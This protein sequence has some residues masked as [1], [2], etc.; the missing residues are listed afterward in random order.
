M[1]DAAAYQIESMLD[2]ACRAHTI[3]PAS[4]LMHH[5]KRKAGFQ[6]KYIEEELSDEDEYLCEFETSKFCPMPIL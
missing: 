1:S 3:L 6:A 5:P 4:C 2:V